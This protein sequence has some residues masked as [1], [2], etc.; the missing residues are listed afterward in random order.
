M[1][2]K[3]TGDDKAK[4]L[5]LSY[6]SNFLLPPPLPFILLF[7]DSLAIRV[8]GI[9]NSKGISWHQVTLTGCLRSPGQTRGLTLKWLLMPLF[10]STSFQLSSA[11]LI[12]SLVVINTTTVILGLV[13]RISSDILT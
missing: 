8:D 6:L 7:H 2:K 9:K 3:E 10:P 4:K 12:V 13:P 1:S 11:S 5:N